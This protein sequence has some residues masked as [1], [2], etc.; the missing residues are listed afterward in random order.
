[1]RRN[2]YI[3]PLPAVPLAA[4]AAVLGLCA[5]GGGA[6]RLPTPLQAGS[7]S[8]PAA[9]NP[10]T[11]SPLPGTRDAAP[12]S[13]ISFL[14]APGM[15][16]A[17]ARVIG[18][19]SGLH[20]GVL[21][22]YST[23]TGE[24]FLPSH[25]FIEGEQ[26][27]VDALV[28]V[29]VPTRHAHTTFT[30]AHR[31]S[32]S[33][34]PFPLNPGD[35]GAVQHY[36]SAPALTPSTVTIT[37]PAR[38]GAAPGDLFLAPY[39]GQGS[40]GP[41]IVDQRGNLVWFQPLPAGE[42]ATNFSVQSYQG[43]PVLTWW[44]GRILQLGFGKG[45]DVLYDSSYRRVGVV[46]AGNGYDVDLH[47]LRLTPEGT[48]WI[49]AFEPV[50]IDPSAS[51]TASGAVTD[52]VVQEID[53][54][55]GLVMWEWHALGHISFSESDQPAPTGEYPWDYVHVNSVDPGPRGDVLLSA[56]STSTVYD[57][58]I[59]SGGVI[60]R[61]GGAHSSFTLAPGVRFYWQHDAEFQPGGLISLFDNGATPARE[62]QS[63]GLLLAP[64]R[65]A[66][67]V[68][69][70]RQ[71]VNP[72]QTLLAESQGN[73]ARLAGGN[74]LLGYGRLPNFTEFD[75]AGHV[76]LDGTLGPNVQ[77]FSSFL[78]R[79][80]GHPTSAPSLALAPGG[81]RA[82]TLTVAASWNGAT[83][84]AAWRV[85]AGPSPTRLTAV[86]TSPKVGFETTIAAHTKG[87]FL[88]V[89]ALDRT[90]AAIA[91]SATVRA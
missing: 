50:R 3:A 17:H 80:N 61:L 74:W 48:A 88:A 72:T 1:M 37:T 6:A 68:A 53:V 86:A 89:Q 65:R 43:K 11:V 76:L 62:T 82:G 8:A 70:I 64:D 15:T 31:V 35:P 51:G 73:A 57:V 54:K 52:S 67:A 29:G 22:A 60:W 47:E 79:W 83:E 25:P 46:R 75:A 66:R 20:A 14:G 49:D 84:V 40:P 41:M 10:A 7:N 45:E 18:S 12:A 16:V 30:V 39:Q 4:L 27:R 28:G 91:T 21:Q 13:Q 24:S 2:G 56:R 32:V 55:T 59:H 38:A 36:L 33:E 19:L 77:N 87:P 90:G 44:Q 81:A 85:L 71:F 63:R 69:L 26:V 34:A 42:D 58:D 23:G 78:S 5:C 9:A